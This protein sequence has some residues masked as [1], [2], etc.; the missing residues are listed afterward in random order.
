[1]N[2]PLFTLKVLRAGYGDSLI[3]RVG[4]SHPY[5]NIIIDGGIGDTYKILIKEIEYIKKNQEVIDLLVITHIDDDHINGIKKLFQNEVLNKEI[6]KKVWFNSGLNIGVEKR[7]EFKDTNI[8]KGVINSKFIENELIEKNINWIR[9]KIIAGYEEL[10][11]E[12]KIKVISPTNDILEKL[13]EQWKTE[14]L[15]D[16]DKSNY[17]DHSLSIERL[18]Q[19]PFQEDKSIPNQSSIALIIEYSG[20]KLLL[21]ADSQPSVLIDC[22]KDETNKNYDIIKVSH[23]GSKNNMNI[24]LLN[25]IKSN[26]FIISTNGALYNHP[27]KESLSYIVSHYKET[28]TLAFNYKNIFDKKI[29]TESEVDKYSIKLISIQDKIIDIYN[30]LKII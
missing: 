12:S 6:L 9:V 25:L 2:Q 22:L 27:D 18:L 7:V 13:K 17:S 16:L 5:S 20:R 3:T 10:I 21:L 19:N 14:K 26:F 1:M 8:N 30:N 23:H 11:G 4:D 15:K 29:F 28:I 24:D